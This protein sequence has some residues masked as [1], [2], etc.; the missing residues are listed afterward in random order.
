[1]K[2]TVPKNASKCCIIVIMTIPGWN[3]Y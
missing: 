2:S 3:L 1:M